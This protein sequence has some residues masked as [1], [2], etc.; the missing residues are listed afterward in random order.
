MRIERGAAQ[1]T[2]EGIEHHGRDGVLKA[3]GLVVHHRPIEAERVDE[4]GLDE[5][6]PAKDVE[7]GARALGGEPDAA[8]PLVARQLRRDELLHHARGRAGRH[9]ERCRDLAHGCLVGRSLALQE[10]D[11]LQVVLDRLGGEHG[12]R[13]AQD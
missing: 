5:A 1:V 4:E 3:L 10:I 2:I 6:M 8:E 11:G 13:L 9:P 12:G 7:R